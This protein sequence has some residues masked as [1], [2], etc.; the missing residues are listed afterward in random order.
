MNEKLSFSEIK[1]DV[2]NVITRNESGMTM[3]QI[4]EELSLSLEYIETIL[5]CAQGFMEDDMEAAA[6]L[7]EMSL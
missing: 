5:T 6:H 2:K 3:N 7:V 1:E 4:A